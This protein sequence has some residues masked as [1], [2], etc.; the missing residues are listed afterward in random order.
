MK[1]KHIDAMLHNFGHSFTSLM[2][3]VDGQYITD[4]LPELARHSAKHEIDI[5]FSN[6]QISPPGEYPA[7]LHESISCW[8][9]WLPRHIANHRLEPERL[10]EIH[11]RYRLVKM[12]H[13]IIVTAIDD[14][15]KE[16]EVFVH[17]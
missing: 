2:N 10:S 14:R 6:G 3:C 17:A 16:H 12:G 11:L 7:V 4:I 8:K 9:D 13:E 1:Y 5:D 15:G